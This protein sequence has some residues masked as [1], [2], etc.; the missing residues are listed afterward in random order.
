MRNIFFLLQKEFLQIFRNPAM[1][2]IIIIL[3]VVQMLVLANAATQEMKNINLAIVDRDNTMESRGLIDAF[4]HSPF[5][6]VIPVEPSVNKATGLIHE[7]EADAVLVIGQDFSKRIKTGNHPGLQLL[8]NAIDGIA[9][10]LINSYTTGII[11]RY[12]QNSLSVTA[13]VQPLHIDVC[14]R[15]WYNPELNYQ[16]Y[17][18]PGILVI[19]VNIIGMFLTAINIVREKEMGTIEQIN[20][21]PIK[22]YQFVIGKLIPFWIIALFDLAFGLTIAHW[23]FGLTIAGSTWLLFSFAAVYLIF[24][25]S[26]G[27]T[28]SNSASNQQQVMF[29]SFLVL[30][31]FIMTSGL[32]TPIESMPLWAQY[33]DYLNPLAY[34]M[35]VNRMIIL[36]GSGFG[37]ILH[38]FIAV[39]ILAALTLLLA[40]NQ[41]R[42]TA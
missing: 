33:F 29:L 23:V 1:L 40:I 41:Y 9:A 36:K 24:A 4:A 20:V 11:A 31:V 13:P 34:F 30:I 3:P 25:L 7:G 17:M 19:L 12:A 38:D 26:L 32:F 6:T 21:T 16:L 37:D 39:V 27:L 8:V 28:L 2:K 15:F 10:S 5:Y 22:R 14:S 35:R 42:K 18:V